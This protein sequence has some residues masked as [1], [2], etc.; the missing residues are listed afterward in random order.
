MYNTKYKIIIII[1]I[2][3]IFMNINLCKFYMI[4]TLQ[5]IV[6]HVTLTIT[7]DQHVTSGVISYV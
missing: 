2:S 4:Y 5:I 6:N 3:A 7:V 1:I